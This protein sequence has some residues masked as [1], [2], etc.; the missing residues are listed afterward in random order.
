[1]EREAKSVILIFYPRGEERKLIFRPEGDICIPM[2][3]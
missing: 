2:F 3:R 1:M